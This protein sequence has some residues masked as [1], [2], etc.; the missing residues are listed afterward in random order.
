MKIIG[1][2][3]Q[4]NELSKGNLKNWF[5]CMN[6]I[7]DYI[8]IYDQNSIDG[9]LDYYTHFANTI[10]ISSPIN[11]FKEEMICKQEL[12]TKLKSDHPDTNWIVAIDGDSLIDGR[13]L[14]NNGQPFRDLCES[15]KDES[16]D[17]YVFG[18]KN[19]WRSDTYWRYDSDYNWLDN[20]GVLPL[21]R[22]KSDMRFRTQAGLHIS[23]SPTSIKTTRRLPYKI[24]HRGFSTDKQIMDKYDLYGS[25]GQKGYLLDRFLEESPLATTRIDMELLPD[26]L[27]ITDDTDPK[28]KRPLREIY[29]ETK[30]RNN[31]S[32]I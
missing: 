4:R 23:A 29:N 12:L 31:I 1:F 14:K 20:N 22:F 10:V 15:L 2:S 30:R 8:Y 16:Y 9:S 27:E 3:Q 5:R 18:F 6:S 25:L 13:L 26:W 11:R 19:L 21:W 24:I 17:G 28:S 7:C 32:N